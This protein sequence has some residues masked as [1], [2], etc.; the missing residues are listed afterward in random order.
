MPS[1]LTRNLAVTSIKARRW[2][3]SR[4]NDCAALKSGRSRGDHNTKEEEEGQCQSSEP[5]PKDN[6]EDA[7]KRWAIPRECCRGSK[8]SATCNSRV[9]LGAPS[10]VSFAGVVA[11]FLRTSSWPLSF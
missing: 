9:L 1:K 4:V 2:T 3:F 10:A 7:Y 8:V 11:R 6:I 5:G